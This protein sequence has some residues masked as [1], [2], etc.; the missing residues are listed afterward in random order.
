M[1]PATRLIDEE[2]DLAMLMKIPWG[3]P[4]RNP[5]MGCDACELWNNKLKTCC[6]VRMRRRYAGSLVMAHP[7]HN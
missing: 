6:A 4:T 7:N 3:D 1:P 2:T 5:A